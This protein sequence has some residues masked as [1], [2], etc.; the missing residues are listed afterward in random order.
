[1]RR[2]RS[3]HRFV[4]VLLLL[5]FLGWALT[6]L[7][8]FIK[9]GYEGAYE[10]LSVKTYP[11]N[12][13]LP[14]GPEPGWQEL[15][16]LRTILG[17]HLLVRTRSGWVNLNPTTHQP[18][19]APSEEQLRTLLSDA[20]SVNPARYGEISTVSENK[21]TTSTGVEVA[22]DWNRMSLQQ[23]GRDTD[24]IEWLYRIHYLQWT[25][26]KSVDRVVGMLGIA[27]VLLLTVLG[28]VLAFKRS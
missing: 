18:T 14:I 16:Y 5:P 4:G 10:I 9:P 26:V 27:L 13:Q 19:S 11:I 22:L 3:V 20:F 8:F 15:R 25:G 12:T 6:G 17:D 21:V 7:V 2:I 1:M 23:K 24:R 28:A